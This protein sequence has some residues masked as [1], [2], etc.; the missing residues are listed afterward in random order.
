[1]EIEYP[2]GSGKAASRENVR[3]SKALAWLR[4]AP[5]VFAE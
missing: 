4:A 5:Y 1:M 2:P 3:H